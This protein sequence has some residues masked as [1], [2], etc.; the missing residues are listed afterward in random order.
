[1]LNNALGM[2]LAV[3][4]V[5]TMANFMVSL[6]RKVTPSDVRIPVYIVI[7]AT[8]VTIVQMLMQAFTTDL[9]VA[10]GV[11]IPLIVVN[12]I[13]LGRAEAYASK[14]NVLDSIIDGVGMGL[15]FTFSLT[16]LAT[17]RQLLATGGL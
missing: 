7:I 1:T 8:L 15:A 6:L 9:Y 14:N 5:L 17:I 2:G 3:V 13:I 16:L 4:V 10:L 11:F 12:C